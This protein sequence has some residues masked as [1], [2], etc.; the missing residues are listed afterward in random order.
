M[1]LMLSSYSTIVVLFSIIAL[2]YL[3]AKK[4]IFT[5]DVSKAL[6]FFV[7]Y[8]A[9]PL[10]IFLRITRDFNKKELISLFRESLFPVITICLI[11][12]LGYLSAYLFKVAKHQ[13]GAFTL[14]FS[15]PSA[16]FIGLPIILGIYGDKGLPFALLVYVVTSLSTW[17]VGVMLLNRDSELSNHTHTPFD[18]K[19]MIKELLS[20]PI[21]SFLLASLLIW[22]NIAPPTV[23]KTLFGYIGDTT[24]ALAMLFIGT[25][26]Y[27][28]GIKK[29]T[30]SKE[31]V[32]I[33]IGRFIVAPL[34]V[35]LLSNIFHVSSMM[36]TVCLIQFSI[37][38]S[39]TV[40]ILA[41]EK[42]VDVSFTDS[43]LTY[44]LITYIF[45]FPIL[46]KLVS[47]C[48]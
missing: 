38:V 46:M 41:G 37:P 32:G 14:C 36:S 17:T 42:H 7:I 33:L 23:I 39:N 44:S 22:F 13:M 29:L 47:S 5:N 40:A 16:A 12:I 3:L 24:S 11:L 34:T 30:F 28:T 21:V 48:F 45:V 2:G 9:L 19:R 4:Q 31:T 1:T 26:I 43:S 6:S 20:P 25:T 35:I 10:E 8:F 18:G 27:Q 15:S